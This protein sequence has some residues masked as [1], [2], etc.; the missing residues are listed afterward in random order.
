MKHLDEVKS[1][2]GPITGFIKSV[3][4]KNIE[5]KT[6][7]EAFAKARKQN[8][9]YFK[10]NGNRYNTNL[11]STPAHTPTKPPVTTVTPKKPNLEEIVNFTGRIENPDSIGYNK[12]TKTWSSPTLP[13][14]DSNQIGMGIDKPNNAYLK[15][16]ERTPGAT[17]SEGREREVRTQTIQ[18]LEKQYNNRMAYAKKLYP[19]FDGNLSQHKANLIYQALYKNPKAVATWWEKD[20]IGRFINATDEEATE[21]IKDF[22]KQYFPKTYKGRN[23][24]LDKAL[25]STTPLS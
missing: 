7:N 6:F 17:L 24:A 11:A 10:W 21:I 9:E 15:D 23:R 20:T 2:G 18:G 8:L 5:A 13:G 12:A 4:S 14:Y 3:F 19:N 22:H 1:N 16:Y 25:A